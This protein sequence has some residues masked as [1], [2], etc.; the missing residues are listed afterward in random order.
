MTSAQPYIRTGSRPIV[1]GNLEILSI[2]EETAEVYEDKL[3]ES[4]STVVDNESAYLR[5]RLSQHPDWADKANQSEVSFRNGSFEYSVAHPDAMDLEYGN[6]LKKVVATGVLRS[7]A[8]GR[9]YDVNQSLMKDLA[10]RL[11]NA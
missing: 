8:K 5:S 3:L 1:S 10:S 6:P 9:E 11:P 4:L 2:L 7:V